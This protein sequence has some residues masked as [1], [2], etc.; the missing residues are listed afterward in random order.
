[1]DKTMQ[2]FLLLIAVVVGGLVLSLVLT[3]LEWWTAALVVDVAL[4]P[5]AGFGLVCG[6]VH[7][8][9]GRTQT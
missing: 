3:S 7:A 5:L 8:C 6:L 1:M 4:L 2:R 9:T